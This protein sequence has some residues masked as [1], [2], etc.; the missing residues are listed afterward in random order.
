MSIKQPK[1]FVEKIID[2]FNK[3]NIR[4]SNLE[5]RT[6]EEKH[7]IIINQLSTALSL[8][9]L[10]QEEP[11][12]ICAEIFSTTDYLVKAHIQAKGISEQAK[13]TYRA[14]INKNIN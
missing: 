6:I 10:A 1:T 8:I 9:C 13:A 4:V 11:T 12:T 14:N 7:R 5:N 3:E 2:T